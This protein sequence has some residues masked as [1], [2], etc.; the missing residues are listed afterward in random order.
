MLAMSLGATMYSGPAAATHDRAF[1]VELRAREFH[2]AARE[3][4]GPLALEAAALLGSTDPQLRDAIAYE[5]LA[6]WVYRDH[7]LSASELRALF[8][9]LLTNAQAGLGGGEND[10]LFLRSFSTLSLALFAATD[11]RQPTLDTAQFDALV[12]LGTQALTTERDL[13]GYVPEKGWG[14]A[15]AHCADLLKFLA[16][17]PRLHTAQQ[18]RIVM[19]IAERTRSA[20]QVFVWGEDARLAAALASVARRQDFDIAPFSTWFERVGREH[21]AIWSGPPQPA[22]YVTERAQ[23]NVLA[24][25]AAAL[26]GDHTG[27]APQVSAALRTLRDA[28]QG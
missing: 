9:V 22:G 15:T 26:D 11:L 19:V 8:Q 28:T 1:W 6:A 24:H 5:A 27:G 17:S 12:D 2:T 13:R 4:V 3:P 23:L 21:E 25:L 18:R 16:R 7:A 10:T 14:H 20:G